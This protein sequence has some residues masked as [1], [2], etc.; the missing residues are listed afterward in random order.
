MKNNVDNVKAGAM[1]AAVQ[2][3]ILTEAERLEVKNKVSQST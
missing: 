2:K 3:E 1:N